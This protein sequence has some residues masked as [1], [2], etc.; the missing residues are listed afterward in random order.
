MLNDIFAERYENTIIPAPS[1]ERLNRFMMQASRMITEQLF[2]LFS[3]DTEQSE[4]SLIL[5]KVHSSL[6]MELG[7]DELTPVWGPGSV[8]PF[9]VRQQTTNFLRHNDAIS[10]A[11]D[12]SIKNRLSFIE[13]SFREYEALIRQRNKS[14]EKQKPKPSGGDKMLAMLQS[15]TENILIGQQ[16]SQ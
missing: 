12:K 11:T 5:K 16:K 8:S 2:P 6:C 4:T 13:L 9:N 15:T 7:L 1:L 3:K 10:F 14:L